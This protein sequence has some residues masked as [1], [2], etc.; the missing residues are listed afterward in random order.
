MRDITNVRNW[1]SSTGQIVKEETKYLWAADLAALGVSGEDPTYFALE[2]PIENA[3][4]W[5]S[6]ITSKVCNQLTFLT[7]LLLTLLRFCSGN[8]S[9]GDQASISS[10]RMLLRSLRE[11]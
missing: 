11:S 8:L 6:K 10:P 7:S 2:G 4:I 1:I 5:A 9:L 3:I